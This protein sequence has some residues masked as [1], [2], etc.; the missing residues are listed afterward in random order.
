[1]VR[2]KSEHS[3]EHNIM[4]HLNEAIK[5]DTFQFI[6]VNIYTSQDKENSYLL[7]IE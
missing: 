4:Q 1:M 5:L 3:M 6:I 2:E 7:V